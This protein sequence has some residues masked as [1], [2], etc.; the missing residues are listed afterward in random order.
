MRT[1][2]GTADCSNVN[3]PSG[4]AN[5]CDR[6]SVAEV[7]STRS[8]DLS[9]FSAAER[10]SAVRSWA[11]ESVSAGAGDTESKLPTS[12]PATTAALLLTARIRSDTRSRRH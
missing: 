5:T 7:I 2:S 9:A 3:E 10:S 6:S 1:R 4:S 12:T 8:P 11:G